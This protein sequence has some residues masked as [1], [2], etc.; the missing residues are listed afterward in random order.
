MNLISSTK[1]NHYLFTSESVGEGHPDKLCDQISD[2]ILDA[3]LK[4]DPNAHVACETFSTTNLILVG[5]E[6]K[7]VSGNANENK[8]WIMENAEQIARK[9]ALDIG[10]NSVDVGLDAKN[11]KFITHCT[12]SPRILRKELK[13]LVFLKGNKGL[14]IKE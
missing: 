5:G 10:Y 2:A 13:E 12:L 8:Q 3:C 1:S 4:R 7:F 9:V 6:I 14:E 11:C